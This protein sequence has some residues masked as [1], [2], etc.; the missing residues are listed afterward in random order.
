MFHPCRDALRKLKL[1]V[2]ATIR[3]RNLLLFAQNMLHPYSRLQKLNSLDF[4]LI[5]F[6]MLKKKLILN[7][8]IKATFVANP[9]C[10]TKDTKQASD[11]NPV[12]YGFQLNTTD[13][14]TIPPSFT[15]LWPCNKLWQKLPSSYNSAGVILMWYPLQ[16]T[17]C[18]ST[19]VYNGNAFIY[20]EIRTYIPFVASLQR[21]G[22][23]T[24]VNLG[25]L[26]TIGSYLIAQHCHT[27]FRPPRQ[28]RDAPFPLAIR[29]SSTYTLNTIKRRL[30]SG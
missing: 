8:K 3:H 30:V 16:H 4:P 21:P 27:Q 18:V 24:L 23:R 7:A 19:E 17:I 15:K 28:P 20:W 9:P 25:E 13:N 5:S 14:V 2:F 10:I 26:A 11:I 6:P 12:L 1:Q 22:K 29:P